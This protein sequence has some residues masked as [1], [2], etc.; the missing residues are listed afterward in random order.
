MIESQVFI[1]NGNSTYIPHRKYKFPSFHISPI[2][3]I[4]IDIFIN[5]WEEEYLQCFIVNFIIQVD[6]VSLSYFH[7]VGIY[8]VNCQYNLAYPGMLWETWQHSLRL[9][10]GLPFLFILLQYS[11]DHPHALFEST[12]CHSSNIFFYNLDRFKFK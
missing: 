1:L 9:N 4:N 3:V 12:I 7:S 11:D 8:F 5:L 2:R 6:Q 10:W